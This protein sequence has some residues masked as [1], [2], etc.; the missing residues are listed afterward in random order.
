MALF[1]LLFR[2]FYETFPE[3]SCPVFGAFWGFKMGAKSEKDRSNMALG[4]S[5]LVLSLCLARWV[6]LRAVSGSFLDSA[7]TRE[8]KFSRGKRRFG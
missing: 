1:R 3:R 2:S 5:F 6:L 4:A 7:H 8:P